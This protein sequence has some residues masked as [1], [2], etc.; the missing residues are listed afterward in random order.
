[1]HE[2]AGRVG[3]LLTALFAL[4]IPAVAERREEMLRL[5]REFG[6]GLQTVNVIRGLHADWRRGWVYVPRSFL[7]QDDIEPAAIFEEGT[8]SRASARAV[9]ELLVQKAERHLGAA[10]RYIERLPRRPHGVR[11]FCMLPY[12]FALRTLTLSQGDTRVFRG[13]VKISRGE[14]ERITGAARLLG[15]SNGWIRWYARRL[16]PSDQPIG[17][18]GRRRPLKFASD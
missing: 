13:E 9:L 14:V 16:S 3:I 17:V 8:S 12:F 2:V 1:M 7:G 18:I 5:G 4:D 15:W 6:L 11:V 10:G